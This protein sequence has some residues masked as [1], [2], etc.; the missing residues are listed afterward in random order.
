[1][2]VA[3]VH[4][5]LNQYGGAERVLEAFCELFPQ[6]PIYTLFYDAKATNGAFEGRDIRTSFLQGIPFVR[7]HHRY[8][9]MLMPLAIEQ[10][11]FSAFDLVL[12]SSASYAKGIITKPSTLHICYCHTPTRY[13][14]AD[15]HISREYASY[16]RILRSLIPLFLPYVRI[17]DRQAAWRPDSFL[18]NSHFVRKRIAKY[19]RREAEVVYPPVHFD[20]FIPG[21]VHDY[22]LMVGRLVPYKRFDI[23]VR[24]CSALGVRLRVVGEGPQ[25]SYLKQIAGPSVEFLGWVPDA[26]LP[27][28]YAGAR[29]LVFPQEEDFGISAIESMAAGRPVI[30]YRGGGALEYVEEGQNGIF[31]DEQTPEAVMRALK[32]FD[33]S[34]FDPLAIRASVERFDKK[35]FLQK[36]SAVIN[37]QRTMNSEQ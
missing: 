10:F 15:S 24:A 1:M 27:E 36:I 16:P 26:K 25:A 22:F 29:A 12:S 2:R 7:S 30:A 8:F 21:T 34:A 17:W 32:H 9:P 33:G 20:R 28:F 6:A 13:A 14:W 18:A 19:Y 31:F 35:Y 5:Y 37:K 23:V 4:D 3:L 11:D